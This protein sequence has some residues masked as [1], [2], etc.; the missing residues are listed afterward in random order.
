MATFDLK[1][2]VFVQFGNFLADS[3]R[4]QIQK[5]TSFQNNKALEKLLYNSVRANEG[6]ISNISGLIPNIL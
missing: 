5:I 2:R 3:D 4:A 1:E 6:N